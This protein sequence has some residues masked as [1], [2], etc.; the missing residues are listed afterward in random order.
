VLLCGA[1]LLSAEAET[2]GTE[3][4]PFLASALNLSIWVIIRILW[5]FL[6]PI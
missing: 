6:K 3:M 4:V 2:G 5:S 1:G